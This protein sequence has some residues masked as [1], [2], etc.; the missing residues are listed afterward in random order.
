MSVRG[1]FCV[2]RSELKPPAPPTV[3]CYHSLGNTD[4]VASG[5]DPNRNGVAP[6]TYPPGVSPATLA[7]PVRQGISGAQ[8]AVPAP[9]A[10]LDLM[11]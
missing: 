10:P 1:S 7:Q 4:C 9:N 3:T 6:I 5:I 11:R 8:P 2:D